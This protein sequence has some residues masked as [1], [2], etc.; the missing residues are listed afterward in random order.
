[1]QNSELIILLRNLSKEKFYKFEKFLKSP[2]HN[3]KKILVELLAALKKHHPDFNSGQITKEKLFGILFPHKFYNDG[4]MRNILSDMKKQAETFLSF[5]EIIAE[6][7]LVNLYK[8]NTLRKFNLEKSYLHVFNDAIKKLESAEIFH[9]DMLHTK[10]MFYNEYNVFLLQYESKFKIEKRVENL[11]KMNDNIFYSSITSILQIYIQLLIVQKS[12]KRFKF[13]LK[14]LKEVEFICTNLITAPNTPVYLKFIYNAFK[15]FQTDKKVYFDELM[16]I[17]ANHIEE[18]SDYDKSNL[19]NVLMTF[20]H[21]Y[22]IKGNFNYLNILFNI[23]KEYVERKLYRE[24]AQDHIPLFVYFNILN[25]GLIAGKINW[26]ENF[27]KTHIGKVM[28]DNRTNLK[29]FSEGQILYS[30]K[31]YGASLEKLA[32]IYT[33]KIPQ[34]SMFAY[35]YKIKALQLKVFYEKNDFESFYLASDTLAHFVSNEKS[36][37]S[38]N[39]SMVLNFL[40]YTKKL[41]QIKNNI[42][43]SFELTGLKKEII[44]NDMVTEKLW[45]ISKI[46]EIEKNL[47]ST[48]KL[49]KTKKAINF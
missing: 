20:C 8:L 44:K 33:K 21:N 46:K 11:Q 9:S 32:G 23:I 17:K 5:E 24:E 29:L 42:N 39:K 47:I 12:L 45:L 40:H 30:K 6:G 13:E 34:A 3:N 4:T 16:K 27:Y 28:S 48:K 25:I 35:K 7:K 36:T 22:M 41:L 18:L 10:F 43:K 15:V 14:Y 2:Y 49:L 19:Y 31:Q 37:I 26:T 1:M 38:E